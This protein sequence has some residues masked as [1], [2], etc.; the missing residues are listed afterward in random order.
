MLELGHKER[1]LLSGIGVQIAIVMVMVFA[2]T[3]AMR[4]VKLQRERLTR[5]QEQLTVA[6][7]E[8][9]KL[10][11]TR[12]GPSQVEQELAELKSSWAAPEGVLAQVGELEK[13]VR[14]GH[15]LSEF[16]VKAG[17]EPADELQIPLDGGEPL[18][19]RLY[20]LEISGYGASRAIGGLLAHLAAPGSKPVRILAELELKGAGEGRP[21]PVQ[22]L[23]RYHVPAV[24]GSPSGPFPAPEKPEPAWGPREEPFLSPLDVTSALRLPAEKLKDL[25]L[26]GI[27]RE[28]V[29]A[30]CVINGRILKPGDWV[31]EYQVVLITEDSVLLQGA[32]DELLLRL[33]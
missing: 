30:S 17:R 15:G 23:A 10:A 24:A 8:L 11:A 28:G 19:I 18:E 4:Q 20:P 13:L 1:N 32:E 12:P 33:P 21:E 16:R 6:R 14:E 9:A 2:Y 7:E 3:Q 29:D 5:L 25:H 31:K 26:S 27:V 22:F